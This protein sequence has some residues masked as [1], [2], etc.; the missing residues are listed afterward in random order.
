MLPT[1]AVAPI[2]V[3]DNEC[4]TVQYLPDKKV[5]YHTVHKPIP[6]QPLKDALNAGTEA[7]RQYGACKWLSDDRKNG[8][9]SQDVS[10]WGM[11]DWSPRTIKA[12][13][14]Y[15]A[16]VVPEELAA[17]GTL[18]P[19]MEAYFEMGLRMMVFSSIKEATAWL[20]RMEG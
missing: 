1:T 3:I 13:W 8:P 14:K 19:V 5:I 11:N 18:A 6:D 9:L 16:N 4:I 15:W 7:L 20:D 2:T 10:A 12:G 17:A